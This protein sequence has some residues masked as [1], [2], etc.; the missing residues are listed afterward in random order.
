M[1]GARQ[2]SAPGR[3]RESPRTSKRRAG[4]GVPEYQKYWWGQAY[5]PSKFLLYNQRKSVRQCD[6]ISTIH[7]YF[8]TADQSKFQSVMSLFENVDVQKFVVKS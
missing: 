6:K 8:Q 4:T 3:Q 5:R 2:L 7:S 1:V